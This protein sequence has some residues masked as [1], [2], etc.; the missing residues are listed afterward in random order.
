M[1]GV[2]ITDGS[3]Y[4]YYKNPPELIVL[5]TSIQEDNILKCLVSRMPCMSLPDYFT[6]E[7]KD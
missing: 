7:E 2:I 4:L 6:L 5:L 3:F 1:N